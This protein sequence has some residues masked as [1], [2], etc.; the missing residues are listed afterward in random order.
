MGTLGSVLEWKVEKMK[1]A[2]VMTH[3]LGNCYNTY[4]SD[5]K[6]FLHI[7]YIKVNEYQY[8]YIIGISF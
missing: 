6:M 7:G 4:Q 5:K 2:V 1:G 8:I 3:Y